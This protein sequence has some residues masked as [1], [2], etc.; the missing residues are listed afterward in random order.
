MIHYT[1]DNET[2]PETDK[3]IQVKPEH[4][5]TLTLERNATL[6]ARVSRDSG[7]GIDELQNLRRMLKD[8]FSNHQVLVWYD[9]VD[10]LV[11]NDIYLKKTSQ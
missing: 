3:I 4:V 6:I 2:L 11:I 10:F 1:I 5:S 7:Y 8:T 9:D